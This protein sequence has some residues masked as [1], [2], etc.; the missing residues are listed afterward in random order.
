MSRLTFWEVV[1]VGRM[2][3]HLAAGL[4]Q[5]DTGKGDIVDDGVDFGRRWF[6]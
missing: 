2:K 5:I 1:V 4:C 3:C 6:I